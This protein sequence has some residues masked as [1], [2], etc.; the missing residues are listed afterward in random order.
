MRARYAIKAPRDGAAF[1]RH[2]RRFPRRDGAREMQEV[3][4]KSQ[5]GSKLAQPADAVRVM[6]GKDLGGDDV[7]FPAVLHEPADF[8]RHIRRGGAARR[9]DHDEKAAAFQAGVQPAFHIRMRPQIGFV[10][11]DFEPAGQSVGVVGREVGGNAGGRVSLPGFTRKINKAHGGG[12][13]Q[14]GIVPSERSHFS[15]F[16]NGEAGWCRATY[17]KRLL[18]R[19]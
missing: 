18:I 1:P 19:L 3:C 16:R 4:A 10:A 12:A 2:V 15:V 13:M 7:V 8:I 6:G 9:A 14:S 5:I 11:K 17:S